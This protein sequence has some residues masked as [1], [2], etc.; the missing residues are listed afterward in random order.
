MTAPAASLPI[1]TEDE[2]RPAC[3]QPGVD[4]EW[5]FPPVDDVLTPQAEYFCERCPM[6]QRCLDYALAHIV[7]GIWAGTTL[8]QRRRWRRENRIFAEPI[9]RD[10]RPKWRQIVD[11]KAEGAAAGV[12]ADTVGASPQ[13]VYCA[14]SRHYNSERAS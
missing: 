8:H 3:A 9:T 4:P 7:E 11:M 13:S 1:T 5:F 12:I 14:I 6:A 10:E 2:T